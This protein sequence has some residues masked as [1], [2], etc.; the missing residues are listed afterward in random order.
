MV[1]NDRHGKQDKTGFISGENPFLPGDRDAHPSW[2]NSPGRASSSGRRALY[3]TVSCPAFARFAL[4][5]L[6]PEGG[7]RE[8]ELVGVGAEPAVGVSAVEQQE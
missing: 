7:R 6:A 8:E 2:S 4:P 3:G 1:N 5:F